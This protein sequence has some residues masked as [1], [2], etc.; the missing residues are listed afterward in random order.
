MSRDINLLKPEL[1]AIYL[2]HQK[3]CIARGIYIFCVYSLRTEAEQIALFAQGREELAKVNQL[4]AVAGMAPITAKENSDIVTKNTVSRHFG[5][6]PDGLSSAYDV[7]IK[8][9]NGS[10][11]DPKIDSNHNLLVDWDEVAEVG[12]ALGLVCGRD[13]KWK[14]SG[15]FELKKKR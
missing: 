3:Q 14:D 6:P 10:V 9:S 8:N 1:K 4:R 13:W 7:A 11:F 15:H 12:R 2:E 5:T